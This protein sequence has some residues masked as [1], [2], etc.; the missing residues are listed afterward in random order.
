MCT[1]GPV[2]EGCRGH[3][4]WKMEKSKGRSDGGHRAHPD[5]E[6]ERLAMTY[7]SP[8]EFKKMEA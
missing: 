2:Q 5:G 1:L 8:L 4:R 7:I 3:E 6:E